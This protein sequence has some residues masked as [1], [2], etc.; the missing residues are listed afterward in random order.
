[1]TSSWT[2]TLAARTKRGDCR[3]QQ[4][5]QYGSPEAGFTEPIGLW[6]KFQIF[7]GVRR[8]TPYI[9]IGRQRR[10]VRL[11]VEKH[12]NPLRQ[13]LYYKALLD[14]GEADSQSGLARLCS[15]PRTTISAYLRLLGLDPKVQAEALALD[16]GRL[17][18]SRLRHLLDKGPGEQH[19][20]LKA[21][22]DGSG[23]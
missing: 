21:L 3:F 15:T 22:L 2:Q 10:S 17:T 18:E 7:Q 20:A 13:A 5:P 14:A 19:R 4:S 1:L 16:D 23:H 9:Q 8:S 12:R 11:K 6:D